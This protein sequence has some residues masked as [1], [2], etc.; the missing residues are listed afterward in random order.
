MRMIAIV[1]LSFLV[2][3]SCEN[4]QDQR[5]EI[6]LYKGRVVQSVPAPFLVGGTSLSKVVEPSMVLDEEIPDGTVY[7]L[8]NDTT[9]YA[10]Q[11]GEVLPKK[12]WVDNTSSDPVQ[13]SVS[14][15]LI[16]TF[17]HL[18]EVTILTASEMIYIAANGDEV[19]FSG[20]GVITASAISTGSE[21]HVTLI[22]T[23]E[24]AIGSDGGEWG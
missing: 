7:G 11:G 2:I 3:V 4:P 17:E 20:S 5:A 16:I 9:V 23:V 18:T 12:S 21:G 15:G 24:F 14:G 1:L 13:V 8:R 6:S 10:A 19:L 22:S